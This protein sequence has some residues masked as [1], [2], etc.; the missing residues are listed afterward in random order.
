[1]HYIVNGILQARILEWV[2][3]PFSRGSSQPRDRTQVSHVAGGFFASWATREALK[4][5]SQMI[6]CFAL[7][8]SFWGF[9]GN[10]VTI[11]WYLLKSCS[12]L[13]ASRG[14][15]Q[16]SVCGPRPLQEGDLCFSLSSL[17]NPGRLALTWQVPANL[18]L[19]CYPSPTFFLRWVG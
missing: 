17:G 15:G 19:Q 7:G 5:W 2:A 12:V 8:E 10:P 14:R 3:F 16:Q 1:M 6:S 4:A 18:P 11:P 13:G 9:S